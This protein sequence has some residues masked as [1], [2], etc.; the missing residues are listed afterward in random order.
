MHSLGGGTGSGF[1]SLLVDRLSQEYSDKLIFNFSIYPG[2]STQ[3]STSDLVVEPYNSVLGMQNLINSVHADFVIEN[4]AL[5][6]ICQNLLK[7]DSPTFADIN[8]IVA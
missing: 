8:Y 3:D 6:K 4:P 1:G 5:Y 7:V 2:S